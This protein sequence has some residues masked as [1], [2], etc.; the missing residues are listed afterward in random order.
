MLIGIPE[1]KDK[2]YINPHYVTQVYSFKSEGKLLTQIFLLEGKYIDTPLPLMEVV[3]S[4][5]ER[6]YKL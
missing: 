2:T 5:N 4:L 1:E 3:T 6:G